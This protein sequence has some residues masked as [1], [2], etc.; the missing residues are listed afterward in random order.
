MNRQ[1]GMIGSMINCITVFLFALF[2]LFD[3]NFGNYVVCM[4]LSMSFVMMIG[5]LANECEADRRAAAN[6]SMIFAGVYCVFICIVYFAQTTSVRLDALDEQSLLMIDYSKS[7]LFFNYDLFGYGMMALATFFIGLTVKA[8]NK[9]DRW[10]KWLLIIHGAFF[11]TC[12]IIPMC[13][14]FSSSSNQGRIVG[15]LLLEFWCIY[16]LPVGILS[17]QHFRRQH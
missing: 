8:D 3:F 10:L 6:T 11:I 16:F 15:I 9:A 1:I 7:G 5:A 4:L 12:F 17:W 2:M 13:G 14:L